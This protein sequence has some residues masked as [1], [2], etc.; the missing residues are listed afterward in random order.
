M[1]EGE[2]EAK[3]QE[4]YEWGKVHGWEP[5]V[6]R[7]GKP[8]PA[9]ALGPQ[10][11]GGQPGAGPPAPAPLAGHPGGPLGVSGAVPG[12]GGPYGGPLGGPLGPHRHPLQQQGRG[13]GGLRPGGPGRR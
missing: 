3:L 5:V 10:P 11:P 12:P 6:W 13:P 8:H 2:F 7:D 9:A 1:A 4:V